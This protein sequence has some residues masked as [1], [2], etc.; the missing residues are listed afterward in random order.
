MSV[1]KFREENAPVKRGKLTTA[2]RWTTSTSR[3]A[4]EWTS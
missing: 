3:S 4:N 2:G 1:I